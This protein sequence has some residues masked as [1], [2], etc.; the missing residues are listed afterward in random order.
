[1]ALYCSGSVLYCAKVHRY[2]V[3][4]RC[5]CVC[6]CVCVCVRP[7]VGGPVDAELKVVMLHGGS[8]DRHI[9]PGNVPCSRD[10]PEWQ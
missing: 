8:P 4:R 1:V 7:S 5:M 3:R 6:V 10:W 9:R 2:L